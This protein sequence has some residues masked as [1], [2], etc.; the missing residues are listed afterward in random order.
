MLLGTI[1]NNQERPL[2]I[3]VFLHILLH[4]LCF[5][6]AASALKSLGRDTIPVRARSA[7][8]Q[9]WEDVCVLS[10]LFFAR[11][12]LIDSVYSI[13]EFFRPVDRAGRIFRLR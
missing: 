12:C 10:S 13:D 11:G 7:A 1:W 8:P 9:G 3:A 4:I 5:R 2:Y 6:G